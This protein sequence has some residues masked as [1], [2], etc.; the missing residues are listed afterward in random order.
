MK[1]TDKEV[2]ELEKEYMKVHSSIVNSFNPTDEQFRELDELAKKLSLVG[3][4]GD[5]QVLLGLMKKKGIN[6]YDGTAVFVELFPDEKP[7]GKKLESLG[8]VIFDEYG[9][10]GRAFF[11]A[12]LTDAGI[13]FVN[14]AL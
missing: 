5:E 2:I 9:D 1:A 4:G 3:L 8:L 12:K 10:E 7:A 11:Q 14:E 6:Q 13:V